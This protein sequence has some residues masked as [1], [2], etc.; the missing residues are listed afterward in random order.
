M[1]K[2]ALA[3][4]KSLESW[5]KTVQEAHQETSINTQISKFVETQIA[6][7]NLLDHQLKKGYQSWRRI[8]N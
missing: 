2:E 1:E 7:S 3:D 8:V 4:I 5:D 6:A